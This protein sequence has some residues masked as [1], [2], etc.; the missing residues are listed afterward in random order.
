MFGLV[1]FRSNH[2]QLAKRGDTFDRL[3]DSFFDQ[4]F[5]AMMP[6]FLPSVSFK[7]D[8]KDKEAEYELTAELPGVKKEDLTLD[9]DNNYLTIAA[10][11]EETVSDEKDQYVCRER[12][13]G[14][15]QRSFYMSNVN[16]DQIEASFNDGVLTV[17]LPK[18]SGGDVRRTIE[19]K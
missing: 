5:G 9:Y 14:C 19:I 13:V 18:L 2:N 3:F 8:V 12:H 1:P 15:M 11:R 17:R 16:R 6:G 7:V 4:P 10:K